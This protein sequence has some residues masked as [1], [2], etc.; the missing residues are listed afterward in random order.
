MYLIHSPAEILATLLVA[1]DK[2]VWTNTLTTPSKWQVFVAIVPP[3]E[4]NKMLC[5]YNTQGVKQNRDMGSKK[6]QVLAGYQVMTRSMTDG[7]GSWM[8]MQLSQYLDTVIRATVNI[9]AKN[10]EGILLPTTEYTIHCV[11]QTSPIM[12][13]GQDEKRR[14]LNTINGLLKITQESP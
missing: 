3:D 8:A 6:T 9:G 10:V 1:N 13:A 4:P 2:A 11:I 5:V 14:F 7:A 12:S